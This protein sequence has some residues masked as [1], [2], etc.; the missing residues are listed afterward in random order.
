MSSNR[1][2]PIGGGGSS[3]SDDSESNDQDEEERR[4]RSRTTTDV[5]D[6]PFVQRGGSTDSPGDAF[7]D[8]TR[9]SRDADQET[10]ATPDEEPSDSAREVERNTLR[11][12]TLVS[13]GGDAFGGAIS[14]QAPTREREQARGVDA[15]ETPFVRDMEGGMPGGQRA[16][17]TADRELVE[18]EVRAREEP[19]NLFEAFARDVDRK[20]EEAYSPTGFVSQYTEV[21]ESDLDPE[22]EF[23]REFAG[24]VSKGL[25]R[26]YLGGSAAEAVNLGADALDR[27]RFIIE[28]PDKE[29][30]RE[31]FFEATGYDRGDFVEGYVDDDVGVPEDE[32]ITG[33]AEE[34]T[35]DVGEQAAASAQ[36]LADNPA[37]IGGVVGEG[38]AGA[39]LGITA[40]AVG[41]RA[42]TGG[43]DA[44]SV[45]APGVS[46]TRAA[47][48]AVRDN[49]VSVSGRLDADAP[50]VEIGETLQ[51]EILRRRIEAEARRA[52]LADRIN[53]ADIENITNAAR[54]QGENLGK[55]VREAGANVQE[56]AVDAGARAAQQLRDAEVQVRAAGV[57]ARQRAQATL[58]SDASIS[59]SA[60]IAAGRVGT[61][62][63]QKAMVPVERARAQL[64]AVEDR[65][66]QLGRRL[67]ESTL[68][69]QNRVVDLENALEQSVRS[70]VYSA[71]RF[72]GDARFKAEFRAGEIYRDTRF[73]VELGRFRLEQAG[74]RARE[75]PGEARS[76]IERSRIDIEESYRDLRTRA[77]GEVEAGKSILEGIEP[78]RPGDVA[79]ELR[80]DIARTKLDLGD[81]ITDTKVRLR[82]EVEAAKTAAK[83][84]D[85]GLADVESPD[86]PSAPTASG[87]KET[88]R[89]AYKA[90]TIR[91][92]IDSK[93]R[94][95]V[96]DTD[97]IDGVG[98]GATFNNLDD[99]DG[100]D[101]PVIVDVDSDVD[102]GGGQ[103][104]VLRQ[105]Q[106]LE[107]PGVSTDEMVDR[108]VID[109]TADIDITAPSITAGAIP[110]VS[111]LPSQ[112]DVVGDLGALATDI[113]QPTG[114]FDD[115]DDEI[116][117]PG[118]ETGPTQITPP[119]QDVPPVVSLDEPESLITDTPGEQTVIQTTETEL[120]G[121]NPD[122]TPR[123]YPGIG[124]DIDADDDVEMV[125]DDIEL[126]EDEFKNLVNLDAIDAAADVAAETDDLF[127]GEEF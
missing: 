95:L 21:D 55:A 84:F 38:V 90:P 78:R 120:V 67:G 79:S 126:D 15:S 97:D 37:E 115:L 98:E 29:I 99:I 28:G 8:A 105:E 22:T 40:G 57:A 46:K 94:D 50:R 113:E 96:I 110:G 68:D 1:F 18:A 24:N 71:R 66:F 74:I 49:R 7:D 82:G 88:L 43:L 14:T 56:G 41:R 4:Q 27:G 75:A 62:L 85:A 54:N 59:E 114:V 11:E 17:T 64:D 108:E 31:D 39:P 83:D 123:R 69:A 33:R 10:E 61:E 35:R 72:P 77:R 25:G 44:P 80:R 104:T 118:D 48:G 92:D 93:S 73:N 3:G 103:R 60:R 36:Y 47:V 112:N 107:R 102:A 111:D 53:D 124:I 52:D 23:R 119:I 19:D 6:T 89:D 76:S 117:V 116:T 70:R 91:I 63:Q 81:A 9:T 34:T 58:R 13:R 30:S 20:L 32:E 109:D 100:G 45:E 65:S 101:D 12:G 121:L 51:R 5:D 127:K 26:F 16:I 87:V 2:T 122:P 42:V 106:E 86:L 125:M